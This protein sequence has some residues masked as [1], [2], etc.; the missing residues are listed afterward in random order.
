MNFDQ[1]CSILDQRINTKKQEN[2]L[3]F[4]LCDKFWRAL[5]NSIPFIPSLRPDIIIAERWD[6]GSEFVLENTGDTIWSRHYLDNWDA[7]YQ[8][9]A[10][11]VG[12][13]KGRVF[14]WVPKQQLWNIGVPLCE[15]N[16]I[17][18]YLENKTNLS[19]ILKE[20][21]V[22]VWQ[23]SLKQDTFESKDHVPDFLV[24]EKKYGLPFVMQWWS[25]WGDGTIIVESSGDFDR[26]NWLSGSVRVSE[27]CNKQY[28]SIYA[29]VVPTWDKVDG[30][31]VMDRPSYKVVWVSQ[32][33]IS[34]VFWGGCDWSQVPDIDM[35]VTRKNVEKIWLY[36]LRQFWYKWAL[37]LEWFFID[38]KFVF[39]ELN[40]RLWWGNE[41]S[42]FNQIL[43]SEI[44]I[45]AIHYALQLGLPCNDLIKK[46]E[47][48]EKHFNR[49]SGG[50]F[51]IKVVWK[52]D[53]NFQALSLSEGLYAYDSGSISSTKSTQDPVTTSIDRWKILL[54]NLPQCQTWCKKDAHICMIEWMAWP[55][56][57]VITWPKSVNHAITQVSNLI[58]NSLVYA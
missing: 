27:F 40:A 15:N 10:Y 2:N 26:K 31:V 32:N 29:C 49:Q 33:G 5:R 41:I 1:R 46:D 22:D 35:E 25:K 45:Q 47:F 18:W 9:L 16:E 50:C 44:P 36:L 34:N 54:S 38:W 52:D 28:S 42:G 57:R 58:Y 19:A 20:A 13:R 14:S 12:S 39:N 7:F 17:R 3:C 55:S 4:I 24:L 37:M 43:H 6:P 56:D 30:I 11:R 48:H 53:Q 51:Y 21:W 23:F 8:K